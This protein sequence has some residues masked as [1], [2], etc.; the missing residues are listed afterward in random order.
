ML[1]RALLEATRKNMS[2]GVIAIGHKL[3]V[4]L[5]TEGI[6]LNLASLPEAMACLSA[7]HFIFNFDYHFRPRAF[8]P[9]CLHGIRRTVVT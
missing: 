8:P 4:K 6:L 9:L 2:V 7:I 3:Y 5:E 1:D